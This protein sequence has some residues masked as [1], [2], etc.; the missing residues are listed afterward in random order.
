M[1]VSAHTSCRDFQG[2]AVQWSRFNIFCLLPEQAK[3][4][5][6]DC[7]NHNSVVAKY[8]SCK[9]PANPG[10]IKYMRE[11]HQKKSNSCPQCEPDLGKKCVSP[12]Q[13]R[14]MVF[15][16]KSSGNNSQY[17]WDGVELN[18]RV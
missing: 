10:W 17:K 6:H 9:Q 18:M 3:A 7:D 8:T 2:P 16:S 13:A 11:I 14:K 5:S 15:T 1:N 4:E 12:V